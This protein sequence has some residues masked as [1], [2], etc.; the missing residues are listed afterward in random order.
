M[1]L[2]KL[3]AGSLLALS[4]TACVTDYPSMEKLSHLDKQSVQRLADTSADLYED[5]ELEEQLE[6]T[7]PPKVM[8]ALQ[9]QW[10]L[11][12]EDVRTKLVEDMTQ[13]AEFP[14][15]KVLSM[16]Y[17]LENA[18]FKTTA[19]GRPYGL[20]PSSLITY[21]NRQWSEKTKLDEDHVFLKGD[22]GNWYIWRTSTV[23]NRDALDVA[24][25][26]MQNIEDTNIFVDEN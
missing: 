22:N 21:S 3:L 5:N 19:S 17:H 15:I 24:Y 11:S 13:T 26:D 1:E 2:R 8:K 14:I 18:R 7:M 4:L 20:V 25:P 9:Q 6:K 16:K 12:E 10:H 23:S